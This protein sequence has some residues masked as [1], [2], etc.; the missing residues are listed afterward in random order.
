M[1]AKCKQCSLRK[2]YEKDPTSWKGR[3]W[4]WHTKFC[5]GWKQYLK[6]LPPEERITLLQDYQLKPRK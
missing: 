4:K 2:K 3:L 6:Q 1:E 5:P